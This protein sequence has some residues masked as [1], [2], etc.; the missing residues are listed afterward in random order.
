MVLTLG[1]QARETWIEQADHCGLVDLTEKWWRIPLY[2]LCSASVL[3]Q[4]RLPLR[5]YCE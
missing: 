4:Y 1:G 2:L 5:H 3:G